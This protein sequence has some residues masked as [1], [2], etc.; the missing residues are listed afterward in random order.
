MSA[1][2]TQGRK[3]PKRQSHTQREEHSAPSHLPEKTWHQEHRLDCKFKHISTN[4]TD[5][6]Y[7]DVSLVDQ[8]GILVSVFVYNKENLIYHPCRCLVQMYTRV[9]SLN[10]YSSKLSWR[11]AWTVVLSADFVSVLFNPKLW[12]VGDCSIRARN[13]CRKLLPL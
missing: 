5:K 2:K 9:C 11:P 1:F 3:K 12:V 13:G 8:E 6:T 7:A 4:N 10:H